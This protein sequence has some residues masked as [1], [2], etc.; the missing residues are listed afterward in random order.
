MWRRRS[1]A[2]RLHRM[3]GLI[4]CLIAL[5]GNLGDVRGNFSAARDALGALPGSSI[6]ASSL[7]Y[8][9]AAIGPA[10]Q[11]DY[12]NAALLMETGIP[13]LSLL[14]RMQAIETDHGRVRSERWG[15]RT[16]DLDL[17]DYGGQIIQSTRLSLPHP[18]MHQR[19][20]VL[21]PLCDIRPG[22]QHPQLGKAATELLDALLKQG[23]LRLPKGEA[24]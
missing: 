1:T 13:P 9:S 7:L 15:P 2:W 17:I 3:G 10:G 8:Q 14:E 11:P 4:N 20:F 24:W 23:G 5:G 18:R 22:W 19:L 12:L 16:L 21:Q 6:R